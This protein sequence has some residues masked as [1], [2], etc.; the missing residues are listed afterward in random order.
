[1]YVP[2]TPTS[3]KTAPARTSSVERTRTMCG[4][5]SRTGWTRR[6]KSPPKR[7]L[8]KEDERKR[9]IDMMDLC[10]AIKRSD[11]IEAEGNIVSSGEMNERRQRVGE[12][13]RAEHQ[14][15]SVDEAAGL[16]RRAKQHC[17]GAD[18]K[19]RS[20]YSGARRIDTLAPH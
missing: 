2:A 6:R 18:K 10:V 11:F 19:E 4:T 12:Q 7:Q 15:I 9:K 20:E 8:R 5:F 17:G 13:K 14:R 16:H 3:V 1:M